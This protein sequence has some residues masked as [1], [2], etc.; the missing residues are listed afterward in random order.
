MFCGEESTMHI[1]FN[2]KIDLLY[3]VVC[4]ANNGNL[5]EL[6]DE[7]GALRETLLQQNNFLS[8][9]VDP[10]PN[11]GYWYYVPSNQ[12]VR[13]HILK[14]VILALEKEYSCK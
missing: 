5:E 10:L 11:T 12:N 2:A 8:S 1:S 3:I 6:L 4:L 13:N 14:N 9:L 7:I